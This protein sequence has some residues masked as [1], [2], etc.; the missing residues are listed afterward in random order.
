MDEIIMKVSCRCVPVNEGLIFVMSS[1]RSGYFE[2]WTR[3]RN[4]GIMEHQFTFHA[5]SLGNAVALAIENYKNDNLFFLC[6]DDD[7]ELI[8]YV[9]TVH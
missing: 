4:Y 1:C 3:V 6:R 7:K 8:D 2:V 5:G 9:G